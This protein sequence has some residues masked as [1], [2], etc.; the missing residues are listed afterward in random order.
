VVLKADTPAE[1]QE[2]ECDMMSFRF[3]LSGG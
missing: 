2:E 3:G 1:A